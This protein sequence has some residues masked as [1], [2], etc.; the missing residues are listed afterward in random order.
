[1]KSVLLIGLGNFGQALGERLRNMGDEVMI[2]DKNEDL[3]NSLS[4]RYTSAAIANCMNMDNLKTLDIPSFDAC[5]VAIGDDFQ[6]SLE[7]TSNLKD[8][9]AKYVVSRADTEIQRKFLLRVGAD[10]VV[11]PNRDI[12][13]KLAVRL[14]SKRVYDYVEL[15]AEHGIFEIAVPQRWYGK[16]LVDA[17]PRGKYGLNVLTIKKGKDITPLPGPTYVFQEG[18]HMLVF[19]KTDVILKFTD[20]NK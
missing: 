6:S 15:D 16:N 18:D 5:V 14:N 11:Y 20:K 3:V 19:G 10:E 8:L 7:I 4:S 17:N 9:G 13:E 1:M 2:V 12:A